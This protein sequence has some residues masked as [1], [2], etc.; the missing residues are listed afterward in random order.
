MEF[1]NNLK[2]ARLTAQLTQQQVAES[3]GITKSTYCGYE[4]GKRQPDVQKIKQLSEIL[5][6]PSDILLGT[7]KRNVPPLSAQEH[8]LLDLFRRLNKEGQEKLIDLADDLVQSEK[9][10]KNNSTRVGAKV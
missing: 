7:G 6:V 4:T 10:I 3:M 2:N 1:A 5:N 9:Y 8:Q